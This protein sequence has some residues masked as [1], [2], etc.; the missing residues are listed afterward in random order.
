MYSNSV[1]HYLA[2]KMC[3]LLRITTEKEYISQV[4]KLFFKGR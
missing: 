4:F 3:T 2:A 1:A